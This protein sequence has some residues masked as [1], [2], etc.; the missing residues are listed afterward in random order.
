MEE[1][2]K[3]IIFIKKLII[4]LISLFLI[5]LIISYLI[6][7]NKILNIL[8]GKIISNELNNLTITLKDKTIIFNNNTY[9]ELLQIY[10]NNQMHE[11][12]IC[13]KGILNNNTYYL[14]KIEHPIIYS[15]DIFSVTSKPCSKHTLISLHSHPENQCIHSKQDIKSHKEFQKNNPNTLSAIMCSKTRFNFY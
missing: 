13:I 3:T 1:E 15:Q 4:I 2:N 9:Q 8:E 10:N 12:K 6:P 5:F 11:F 14:N 7:G